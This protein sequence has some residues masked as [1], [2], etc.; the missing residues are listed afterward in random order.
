MFFQYLLCIH[1]CML[2]AR[3][4]TFVNARVCIFIFKKVISTEREKERES[5]SVQMHRA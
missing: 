3:C 5:F 1:A 4:Y 2:K